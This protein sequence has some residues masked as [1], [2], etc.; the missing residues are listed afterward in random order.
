MPPT[1]A[2]PTTA[3]PTLKP[4]DALAQRVDLAGQL[5]AGDE[6]QRRLVLVLAAG[7]QQ[8]GEVDR[9]GADPDPHLAGAGLGRRDLLQRRSRRSRAAR[10]STTRARI[11]RIAAFEAFA[12]Q[13]GDLAA[14]DVGAR[15]PRR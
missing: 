7:L 10:C 1:R 2:P 11:R 13:A 6:G 14:G 5:Q 15:G 9:G 4:V 8:V 3:S 12:H